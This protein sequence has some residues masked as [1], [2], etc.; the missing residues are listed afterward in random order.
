MAWQGFLKESK[1][2]MSYPRCGRFKFWLGYPV[3]L[4]RFKWLMWK[5]L[6]ASKVDWKFLFKHRSKM[7]NNNR[8]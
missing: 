7:C 5:D 3:A 2:Y 8:G 6:R 4:V 1:S